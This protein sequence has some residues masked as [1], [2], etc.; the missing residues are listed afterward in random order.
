MNYIIYKTTNKLNGKFYIGAHKTENLNDGYLG[1]GKLL[2][3][4]IAKYGV[5]NFKT[6]ILFVYDNPEDMYKKKLR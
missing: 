6:Q 2:K 5:E 1:S 3:R 4:A